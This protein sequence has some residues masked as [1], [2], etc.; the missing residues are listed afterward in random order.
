MAAYMP[1]PPLYG[2]NGPKQKSSMHAILTS[3]KERKERDCDKEV[4]MRKQ[5][6]QQEEDKEEEE[7]LH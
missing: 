3:E 7:E 2:N 6:E 1:S 5:K 4:R